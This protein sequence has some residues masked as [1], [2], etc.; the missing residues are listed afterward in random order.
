MTAAKRPAKGVAAKSSAPA[1]KPAAN[2]P[3]ELSAALEQNPEAKAAFA[4]MPPSHRREHAS[5]IAEAKKEETRKRRAQAAIGMI[6]QWG[7]ERA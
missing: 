7:R 1:D 6:L 2:V 3:A 4:K 5:H